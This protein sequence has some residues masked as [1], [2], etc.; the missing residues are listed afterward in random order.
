LLNE[1]P[2]DE[3]FSL[4]SAGRASQEELTGSKTVGYMIKINPQ[5]PDFVNSNE[6]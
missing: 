5:K 6:V 4:L 2:K 3:N 1:E